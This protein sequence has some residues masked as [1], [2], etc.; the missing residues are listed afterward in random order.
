MDAL[1]FAV[2]FGLFVFLHRELPETA[3]KPVVLVEPHVGTPLRPS[4]WMEGT[5]PSVQVVGGPRVPQVLEP[6]LPF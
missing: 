3:R 2:V 6:G 4:P 1:C 5:I